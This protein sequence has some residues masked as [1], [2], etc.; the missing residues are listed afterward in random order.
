MLSIV[1]GPC[2]PLLADT[3]IVESA[4]TGEDLTVKDKELQK[5]FPNPEKLTE[6]L[7][8]GPARSL[9]RRWWKGRVVQSHFF[10]SPFIYMSEMW[11]L[12]IPSVLQIVSHLL[13]KNGQRSKNPKGPYL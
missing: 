11:F 12:P 6:F 3:A 10:F 9:L 4:Q 5:F 7:I 13:K 1:K 8:L 2:W